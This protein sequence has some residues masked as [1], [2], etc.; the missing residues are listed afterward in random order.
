[1]LQAVSLSASLKENVANTKGPRVHKKASAQSG[2]TQRI[3]G[4]G[5][6]IRGDNVHRAWRPLESLKGVPPIKDLRHT[7]HKAK[8]PQKTRQKKLRRRAAAAIAPA[9]PPTAAPGG[10]PFSSPGLRPF[11]A[12]TG[13]LRGNP[14]SS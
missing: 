5:I 6:Q 12:N 8:A 3:H 11:L 10:G 7:V 9:A 13:D 14:Y 1:M 2:A 4:S